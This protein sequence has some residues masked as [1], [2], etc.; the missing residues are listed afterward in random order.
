MHKVL[1][2]DDSPSIRL[3]VRE[4]LGGLGL[5]FHEAKNGLEGLNI[6]G[7]GI[8]PDLVITDLNMPVMDGIE[9]TEKIKQAVLFLPVIMMS[10]E[11]ESVYRDA[12]KRAGVGT[13]LSKP[14]SLEKLRAVV[15][16]LLGL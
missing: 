16:L 1:L 9:M 14:V 15:S 4:A 5:E 11:D 7:K 12:A 3:F 6:V 13:W 8:V 10:G 2:V